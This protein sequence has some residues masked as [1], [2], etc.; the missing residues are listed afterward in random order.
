M[1][2]CSNVVF[3]WYGKIEEGESYKGGRNEGEKREREGYRGK[4]PIEN[5][6]RSHDIFLYTIRPNTRRDAMKQ[7][8][9]THS[10]M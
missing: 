4:R 6:V 7:K 8:P 1:H 3:H 9:V 5:Q 10:D 2:V